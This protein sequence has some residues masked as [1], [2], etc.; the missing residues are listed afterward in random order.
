MSTDRNLVRALDLWLAEGH[1]EVN[2]HVLDLLERRIRRERQRPAW[3][4]RRSPVMNRNLTYGVAAAAALVVAV[5]GWNLLPRQGGPGGQGSPAPSPSAAVTAAPTAAPTARPL[6]DGTLSAGRYR[7]QLD[8]I[9]PGLSVVAAV[10]SG[11]TG[12]PDVIALTSSG[13]ENNGI[14]LTFMKVVGLFGDPCQ[15]DING[16]GAT[17]Q[18]GDVPVGPT[19]ADL[20]AALEANDSYPSSTPKPL[21]LGTFQGQ[22][23]ELQLPGFEVIQGCDRREGQTVG[24]YFV[25]PGG[26]YAQS[27]NSRW[28]LSIVDVDGSRVVTLVSIAEGTPATDIAAADAIV[29]SFEF[30]P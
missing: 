22:E 30:T 23:I 17:D 16:T 29:Q 27:S 25:F 19:V 2:D 7:L 14:L 12:H 18:A 28:R 20:V 26:F 21:L 6:P 1:D 5:V 15:W 8:F 13:G 11:W 24:D 10:P 3:L 4:L 9:D